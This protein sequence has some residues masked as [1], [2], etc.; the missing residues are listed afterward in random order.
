MQGPQGYT[1]ILEDAKAR[2]VNETAFTSP[3]AQTFPESVLKEAALPSPEQGNRK[4]QPPPTAPQSALAA[5]LKFG[6]EQRDSTPVQ[7][8]LAD[9]KVGH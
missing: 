7:P 3:R 2:G 1:S 6:T 4:L 5:K 8:L 9:T